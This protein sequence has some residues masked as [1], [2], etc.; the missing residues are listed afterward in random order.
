M[1]E[2]D[3]DESNAST[4]SAD[5]VNTLKDELVGEQNA[6]LEI[7]RSERE[8]ARYKKIL[9]VVNKTN[10]IFDQLTNAY[11][12]KITATS[13]LKNCMSAICEASEKIE[14]SAE[15]IAETCK[16]TNTENAT[17]YATVTSRKRAVIAP[18]SS[19][20]FG[21]NLSRLPQV[22]AFSLDHR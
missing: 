4:L 9:S 12:C 14:S 21:E 8:T 3:D 17:T 22:N 7:Y 2:E 20:W 5:D 15:K 11:L 13:Y 1:N 16:N 10:K 6:L 19:R 18:A